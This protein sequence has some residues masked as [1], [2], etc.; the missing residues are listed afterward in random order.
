MKSRI[1]SESAIMTSLS[2]LVLFLASVS[3]VNKIFIASASALIIEVFIK[4]N[5]L[6]RSF[7]VFL[8]T[9]ILSLLILP[10]K[11]IAILYILI[12]GGYSIVRN[13]IEIKHKWLKKILMVLY[14]DAVLWLLFLLAN[15][16]FDNI[17]KQILNGSICQ[18]LLFFLVLQ[19][20]VLL[21]DFGLDI[22]SKLLMS[23]LGNIGL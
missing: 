20:V 19:V 2:L 1:I 7:L 12:F 4:R 10:F 22:A 6:K 5:T 8:P 23:K 13:V 11:V 17:F 18:N 3:P 15:Q 21:Y 14:I 16:L 9:S